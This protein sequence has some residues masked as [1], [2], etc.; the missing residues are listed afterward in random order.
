MRDI[1]CGGLRFD[2]YHNLYFVD[3]TNF[4]INKIPY[5]EIFIHNTKFGLE[6]DGGAPNPQFEKLYNSKNAREL[7][8]VDPIC[9]E[10]KQEFLYWGN[11]LQTDGGTIHM[12][13][14]EPFIK[15]IPFQTYVFDD[16][17]YV[18]SIATNDNFLFFISELST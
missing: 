3:R 13:F 6:K 16:L 18:S 10:K 11:S 7:V 2:V 8:N 15:A 17:A 5:E 9:I 1:D 12:G 4:E 14:T